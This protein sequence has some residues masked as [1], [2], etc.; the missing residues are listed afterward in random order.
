MRAKAGAAK[1]FLVESKSLDGRAHGAVEDQNSLGQQLR[2]NFFGAGNQA[3][4][5]GLNSLAK[6]LQS[7]VS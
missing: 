3:S 2:Q 7:R 5:H 6:S 4:L 1:I